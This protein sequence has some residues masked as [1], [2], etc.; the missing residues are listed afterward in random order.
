MTPLNLKMPILLHFLLD[1]MFFKNLMMNPSSNKPTPVD[2]NTKT[3][4]PEVV[5]FDLKDDM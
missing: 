3:K 1:A 2:T 4:S 5:G